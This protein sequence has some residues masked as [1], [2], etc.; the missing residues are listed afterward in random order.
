MSYLLHHEHGSNLLV[1]LGRLYLVDSGSGGRC[2][3]L[4][5]KEINVLLSTWKREERHL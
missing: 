4:L 2:C 5:R 1:C 3:H